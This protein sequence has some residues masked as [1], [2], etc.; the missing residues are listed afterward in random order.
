MPRCITK[1]SIS[2]RL[3][4]PAVIFAA[5]LAAQTVTVYS[6]FT[7][8]DPFG[9]VVRADR[10]AEPPREILSPAIPRNA[11]SSFHIVVEG[12][13]GQAYR[14]LVV[15]NPDD[16]VTVTA[17]REVYTKVGGEWVPDALEPVPNP[18]DGRLGRIGGSE[19]TAQAFWVDL[20]AERSAPVRRIRIEAQVLLGEGWIVTPMEVRVR[21]A[22]L[23]TGGASPEASGVSDV[24][25]PASA[26]VVSPWRRAL[27]GL[28]DEMKKPAQALTIRN[29]IT[30]NAAQDVKLAGGIAPPIL[31]RMAGAADR[32][33]L[34]RSGK[35]L[36]PGEDYL[37]VRDILV[38]ARE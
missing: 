35:W 8:I 20:F 4:V 38:G 36:R 28:S 18:F 23:G 32:A 27:C 33:A 24:S 1:N 2:L 16:A 34:C 37:G 13:P 31:L 5:S 17:Y 30:R 6:E 22:A 25:L 14:F 3:L 12:Q 26:S 21:P 9:N 7:R 10:G 29:F 15:Q 19:Q 11:V